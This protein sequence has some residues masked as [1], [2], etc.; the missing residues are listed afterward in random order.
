MLKIAVGLAVAL[1]LGVAAW[2][3]MYLFLPTERFIPP[4]PGNVITT[5]AYGRVQGNRIVISLDV[6]G[7]RE[8]ADRLAKQLDGSLF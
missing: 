5:K 3:L 2:L 7:T 1:V 6:D 8:D 4:L